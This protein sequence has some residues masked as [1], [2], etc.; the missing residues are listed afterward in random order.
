M[1]RIKEINDLL[2]SDLAYES[3]YLIPN[4]DVRF[5]LNTIESQKEEIDKL[6]EIQKVLVLTP[7]QRVSQAFETLEELKFMHPGKE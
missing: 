4:N 5:L 7:M 2:D 3:N 1:N 6:R